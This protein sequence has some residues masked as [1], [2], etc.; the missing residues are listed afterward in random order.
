ML[1]TK[2]QKRFIQGPV[3]KH[4]PLKTGRANKR[5]KAG[6]CRKTQRSGS[7]TKKRGFCAIKCVFFFFGGLGGRETGFCG[8]R[9]H[10]CVKQTCETFR[11]TNI[12]LILLNVQEN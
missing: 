3:K 4:T 9:A 12:L 7:H 11:L 10:K 1:K 8:R 6:K 5:P 2:G